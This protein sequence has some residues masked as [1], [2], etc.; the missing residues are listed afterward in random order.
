LKSHLQDFA[1]AIIM[2]VVG[3]P[4]SNVPYSGNDDVAIIPSFTNLPA[5]NGADYT[6]ALHSES[7]A[8]RD[9]KSEKTV[10][11][12]HLAQEWYKRN[13][14]TCRERVE[15]LFDE[16]RGEYPLDATATYTRIS[17]CGRDQ[18][19]FANPVIIYEWPY[20]RFRTLQLEPTGLEEYRQLSS[21][22]D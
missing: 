20:H 3:T 2:V 9:T 18:Y 15:R 16:A 12:L 1:V 13:L 5:T 21:R 4:T 14:P 10:D 19:V 7:I 6:L 22:T 8:M 11:Q 17:L